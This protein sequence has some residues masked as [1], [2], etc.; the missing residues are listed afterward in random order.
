MRA[1]LFLS[2]FAFAHLCAVAMAQ[3]QPA[4]VIPQ[5]IVRSATYITHVTVIDTE[6]GKQIQDRTVIAGFPV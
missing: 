6:T 4:V 5:R 1:K 3:Q 2:L